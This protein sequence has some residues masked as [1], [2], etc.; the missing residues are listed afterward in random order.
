MSCGIFHGDI[1]VVDSSCHPAAEK[2]AVISTVS[3]AFRCVKLIPDS[4]DGNKFLY[5]DEYDVYHPVVQL[6]GIVT[7]VVRCL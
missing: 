7:G 5:A 1:L 3:G 6:F 2:T 4:A